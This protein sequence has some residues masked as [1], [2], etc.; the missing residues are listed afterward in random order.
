MFGVRWMGRLF[1]ERDT[2]VRLVLLVL[3]GLSYLLFGMHDGQPSAAQWWL[4]VTAFAAVLALHRLP[5]PSL[6][7]Q[8][9]LLGAAF[10]VLDDPTVN[11]VGASWALLELVMSSRAPA[12]L[13]RRSPCSPVSTWRTGRRLARGPRRHGPGHRH[14]G[15]PARP[16]RP[17]G[18]Q[19]PGAGAAG[20]TAG[21]G[22]APPPRVRGP[23]GR[24]PR[25]RRHRP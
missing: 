22:G 17:A 14:R 4:A 6:V 7:V 8:T 9:A 13:W 12:A 15:R 19:F 1:D 11:Q 5:L 20:R 18:S 25:A 16:V 10:A 2:L 23:R 3:S 21:R 24:R